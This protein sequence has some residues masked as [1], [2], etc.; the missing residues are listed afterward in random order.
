MVGFSGHRLV[1]DPAAAFI[2]LVAIKD[3]QHRVAR[4]RE[5]RAVLNESRHQLAFCQ[6]WN[7]VERVVL[8]TERALRQEMLEWHSS[9][10]FTESH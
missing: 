3:L 6:T 2:S 5:L 10:S 1:A 8:K 9:T 7:S 4:Y